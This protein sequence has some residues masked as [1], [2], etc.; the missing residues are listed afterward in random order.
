MTE[1]A[2]KQQ[3][4]QRRNQLIRIAFFVILSFCYLFIFANGKGQTIIKADIDGQFHFSRMMSLENIWNSPVNFEYFNHTGQIVN[5]MYPWVILYPMYLLVKLTGNIVLGYYIYFL[6]MTFICLE[7]TYWCMKKMKVSQMAA[8]ISAVLYAFSVCRTS[9]IYYR[10]AV[11]EAIGMTFF[12]LVLLGIYQIF[13]EDKPKWYTLVMGMTLL[14]YSHIISVVLAILLVG[15][16][17]IINLIRKKVDQKRIIALLKATGMTLILSLGFFIPMLQMLFSVDLNKPVMYSLFKMAYKPE[18]FLMKSIS[19]TV[20][21][22]G[23][24]NIAF[25]IVIIVLVVNWKRIKGFFKD[26]LIMGIIFTVMATQIFPWDLF[27]KI[28]AIIQFPGRLIGLATLLYAVAFGQV[29]TNYLA[30]HS[31]KQAVKITLLLVGGIVFL[32]FGTL[33]SISNINEVN[34]GNNNNFYMKAIKENASFNGRDDYA[35]K[36]ADA[37]G[38]QINNQ[39][40]C[41]NAQ[42]HNLERKVTANTITYKYN[43]PNETTAF[44]PVYYYPGEQVKQNGKVIKAQQAADGATL[45]NLKQGENQF[46]ISY[47]YTPLARIAWTTSLIAC[48]IFNAMI[49]IKKRKNNKA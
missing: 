28:L 32:H 12:P 14:V 10:I 19:N 41:A 7:L 21:A 33:D 6:I 42:W 9:D 8:I 37:D 45:V 13:Y 24:F 38:D 31:L 3:K 16:F 1:V 34:V 4:E 22:G 20:D 44:L 25:I 48:V 2:V 27:Q 39:M 43:S 11:G 5:L 40:I 35:P 46:E 49:L 29:M 23:T 18:D 47:K 36:K 17:F 15:V 26:A 30:K